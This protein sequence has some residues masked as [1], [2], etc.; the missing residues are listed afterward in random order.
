MIQYTHK[1]ANRRIYKN[2]PQPQ[3]R[4]NLERNAGP[5]PF[6]GLWNGV[7]HRPDW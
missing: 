6:A 3:K 4:H 5:I 2:K 7:S 1:N